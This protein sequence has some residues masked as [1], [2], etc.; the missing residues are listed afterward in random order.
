MDKIIKRKDIKQIEGETGIM[1]TIRSISITV[2]IVPQSKKQLHTM[3]NNEA[4]N[5][6]DNRQNP[7]E[8]KNSENADKKEILSNR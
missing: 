2:N 7:L 3:Y 5:N 8:N 6:H 4:A 1:I